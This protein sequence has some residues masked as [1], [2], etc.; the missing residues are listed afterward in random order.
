MIWLLPI[1]LLLNM[2]CNRFTNYLTMIR[3]KF[4]KASDYLCFHET[5]PEPAIIT[6]KNDQREMN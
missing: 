1:Q 3:N 2:C 4:P 5:K 6:F